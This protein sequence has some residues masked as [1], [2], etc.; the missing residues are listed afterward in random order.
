MIYRDASFVRWNDANSEFYIDPTG[1]FDITSSFVRICNAAKNEYGTILEITDDTIF[2]DVD[3]R[4]R[5]SI[6]TSG[7]II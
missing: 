6:R 1:S 3:D 7:R 2:V 4:D 5:D